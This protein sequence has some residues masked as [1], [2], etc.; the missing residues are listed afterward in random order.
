[1]TVLRYHEAV[2]QI[3]E[4]GRPYDGDRVKNGLLRHEAWIKTLCYIHLP[5]MP[6]Y[7]ANRY[8]CKLQ[9]CGLL[10]RSLQFICKLQLPKQPALKAMPVEP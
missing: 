10:Q 2:L 8:Y 3:L 1:M 4:Q 6:G 7:N 5:N 9:C